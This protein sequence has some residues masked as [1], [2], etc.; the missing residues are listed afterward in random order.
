[1]GASP[2]MAAAKIP[3]K[4]EAMGDLKD[5]IDENDRRAGIPGAPP[6]A[7]QILFLPMF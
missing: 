5:F 6:A 4:S 3:E 1:M 7:M 2:A